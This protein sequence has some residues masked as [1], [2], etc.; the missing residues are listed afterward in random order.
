M[1]LTF[2]NKGKRIRERPKRHLLW[3]EPVKANSEYILHRVSC[4]RPSQS[5]ND[6]LGTTARTTHDNHENN[7]P[8]FIEPASAKTNV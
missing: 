1:S 5:R 4:A 7:E 3:L 8:Q 6:T 2:F